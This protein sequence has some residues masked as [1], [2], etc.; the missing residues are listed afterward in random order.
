MH[1]VPLEQQWEAGFH[2]QPRDKNSE[3]LRPAAYN[4]NGYLLATRVENS[5]LILHMK[6]VCILWFNLAA[7]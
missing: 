5:L 2:H 7:S 1:T 3:A 4:F 6:K